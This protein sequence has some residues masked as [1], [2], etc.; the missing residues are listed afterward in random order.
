MQTLPYLPSALLELALADLEKIEVDP[1]FEINMGDWFSRPR[2]DSKCQVC[3]AGAVMA[4]TLDCKLEI[5]GSTEKW[6]SSNRLSPLMVGD[7]RGDVEISHK[8]R[9]LNNF[10]EG[11]LDD[12]VYSLLKCR[13]MPGE[14]VDA[15]TAYLDSPNTGYWEVENYDYNSNPEKF[16]AT[17]RE[18]VA[19]FKSY[20][21]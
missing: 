8:L 13:R 5:M 14:I 20:N 21:L 15:L 4:K 6:G 3:L 9:A 7:Q 2:P 10:R 1:E 17:M 18:I 12:G 16:K 19:H 11:A